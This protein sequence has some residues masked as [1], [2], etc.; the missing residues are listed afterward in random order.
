MA[1]E[2]LL[3]Q[4]LQGGNASQLVLPQ[5]LLLALWQRLFQQELGRARDLLSFKGI[6]RGCWNPRPIDDL[7]ASTSSFFTAAVVSGFLCPPWSRWISS[8]DSAAAFMSTM[9]RAAKSL[10]AV[11]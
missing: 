9:Q 4:L 1:G 6:R 2:A 10:L 3:V 11:K 8:K 7:L 5:L